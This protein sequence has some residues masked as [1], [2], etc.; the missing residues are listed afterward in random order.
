MKELIEIYSKRKQDFQ[1][2]ADRLKQKYTQFAF[3]RL[4]VF[5]F[6]AVLIAFLGFVVSPWLAFA[7]SLLFLYL[8]Y[9]FVIWHQAIQAQHIHHQHLSTINS[10]EVDALQ[11]NY[12]VFPDGNEFVK[13]AHP[14]T[15]DLDIFG[16]YSFFQFSNRTSSALGSQTLARY[17]ENPLTDISEIK[18]RQAAIQELSTKL[19]W[20]QNFQAYG[21]DT[22][23][24]VKHVLALKE[25]LEQPPIAYG[26]STIKLA[27]LLVPLIGIAGILLVIFWLPWQVLFLFFLPAAYF[28]K[29]T[30]EDINKI[31]HQTGDAD[32]ILSYY[33]KLIRAIENENFESPL[34]QQLKGNLKE[35][36]GSA[37]SAIHRL[38]YIIGQ[39]N[40]RNN[41][42]TLFLNIIGIWDLQW[43]YRLEKWKEAYKE[44]LVQWFDSMQEFEALLSLGTV[45]YNNPDWIFPSVETS[46]HTMTAV[47]AGHPL[48]HPEK[49][50]C[51]DIA[52]PEK[53]HI[54]LLTGS[55]MAGKS[56]LLRTVGLNIVL[57]TI[58]APV[59][60]KKL[61]LPILQVYTSMRTQD[62]L[63]ESTSSFYAELKRLKF[64]IE[65]VEKG[66]NIFFLLDEILKGTNSNDRHTGSKALIKQLINDGGSGIIATHDLELGALEATYGGAIENLCM[67]VEV[68]NDKLTFDYKIKKGVSQS[69]NATALMRNMGIKIK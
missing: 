2:E 44:K 50:I 62:A 64:I 21:K 35:E 31:A 23:D 7:A 6:A 38:S 22:E 18:L 39:L 26:N 24:E 53:E 60:A 65:A 59:C 13:P 15:V 54:K 40:L 14:Y 55:N 63:H 30:L 11:H 32:K 8:F 52:I 69:F 27:L 48:I 45:R 46:H 5:I 68:E 10:N 28:L 16:P 36:N 12:T 61:E 17:F 57:A 37:S 47:E 19:D 51:N 43:V 56:T 41:I 42:F 34:L 49:R 33:S 3:V 4:G 20:R 1:Q 29:N 58:G 25:W 66:D 67:E 9:R